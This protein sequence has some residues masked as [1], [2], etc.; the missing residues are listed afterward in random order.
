MKNTKNLIG[1]EKVSAMLPL[2]ALIALQQGLNL[3]IQRDW[4]IANGV[5]I[6]SIKNN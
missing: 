4:K 2:L 6:N 1:K 5:L 3:T